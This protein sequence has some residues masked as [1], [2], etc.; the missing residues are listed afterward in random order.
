[1]RRMT[2]S[3]P[4]NPG[5]GVRQGEGGCWGNGNSPRRLTLRWKPRAI[6][7]I[8]LSGVPTSKHNSV[9]MPSA[10]A[11][12]RLNGWQRLWVVLMGMWAATVLFI[13][14]ADTPRLDT[15]DPRVFDYMPSRTGGSGFDC[16]GNEVK[17]G[18]RTTPHVGLPCGRL[19]SPGWRRPV[20]DFAR[21]S[22]YTIRGLHGK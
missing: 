2:F 11:M 19:S 21:R 18:S 6:P 3:T 5:V 12:N 20:L 8:S 1:M 17:P 14:F 15:P 9:L 16:E 4:G 10:R 22:S 7:S 13:G